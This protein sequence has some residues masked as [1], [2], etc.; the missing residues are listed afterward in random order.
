MRAIRANGAACMTMLY[1]AL[2]IGACGWSFCFL[3]PGAVFSQ[4]ETTSAIV[5]QVMDASGATIPGAT[6][7][8]TNR[9]TGLTRTSETDDSGRFSFPQLNPGTYSVKAEAQG[10]ESQQNDAV[11]SSLGQT[12]PI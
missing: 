8:I 6:V 10:F 3:F 9:E 4:G 11:S 5:G 2:L 1:T 12:Q 7:T